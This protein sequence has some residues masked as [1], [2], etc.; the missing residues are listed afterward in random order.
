MFAHGQASHDAY[1]IEFSPFA[2]PGFWSAPLEIRTEIRRRLEEI[3]EV[4]SHLSSP[5]AD[6]VHST[7]R[8]EI[9]GHIVS[10]ILSDFRRTLTVMSVV[11]FAS[12][13]PAANE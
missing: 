11:S 3:V 10:Y 8:I 7:L 13:R 6:E 1:S 4:A 2:E 12:Q 5:V 9:A